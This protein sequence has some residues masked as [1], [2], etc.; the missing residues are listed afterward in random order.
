MTMNYK[1]FLCAGLL[2]TTSAFAKFGIDK[3]DKISG[4][5]LISGKDNSN[6]T[7]LGQLEKTYYQPIL[8]VQAG[9]LNFE[10]KCNNK[11]KDKRIYT[12]KKRDCKY[13]N[14]NIVESFVVKN[15]KT[16]GWTKA[17]GE[18]ERF[19]LG[20]KIYN[21]GAFGYYELV[22]VVEG[23]NN[24]NQ[25]TLTITQKMLSD[26]EAKI[27]VNTKFEKDSAFNHSTTQFVLTE[28]EANKTHLAFEYKALTDHWVLN[29]EVSIPQVFASISKSINDLVSSI[30]QESIIQ[31]RNI[32]AQE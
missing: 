11:F 25:K 19:I 22:T 28:I 2:L 27:Y 16:K 10:S 24:K 14:E 1:L 7:Y 12:D 20:R 26:K 6:R 30:D 18:I 15:I 23:K 21:R 13:H 31:S 4:V 3:K 5:N 32:A 29:K 17:Q 9:I 8:G